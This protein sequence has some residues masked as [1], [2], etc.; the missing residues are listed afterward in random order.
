MPEIWSQ[1]I[2]V[3]LILFL[4]FNTF[5][6][7][8]LGD[9]LTIVLFGKTGN[10]KSATGNSILGFK[11]F[12]DSSSGSSVTQFCN[13]GTRKDEREV[14]VIDT[15]GIMDTA[16]VSAMGKVKE[17]AKSVA[18]LNYEKQMEILRELAKV[19]VMSP[20][21]LDAIIITIKYG[22]RF[23]K[24]D[25]DALEILKKF[26]GTEAQPYMILILTH[27]DEAAY[28]AQRG[29]KSIEDVLKS[30]IATLPGLVQEFVKEI[31]E[32][33]ILFNNRLDLNKE[34]DDCKKQVSRLLQV[35]V[36]FEIE[37]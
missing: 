29:E 26:F 3:F 14:T 24:E 23:G 30:Y 18:G 12:K 32:R 37:I 6:K 36:H 31:G 16:Q 8:P 11:C 25:T 17:I 9:P 15:P 28:Q 2:S 22:V 19:F 35:K 20:D 13:A 4:S 1:L 33:R 5:L 7:L 34:P 27:G 10:G 21:G